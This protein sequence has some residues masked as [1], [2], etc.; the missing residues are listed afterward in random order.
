M[1]K[2][3]YNF[4][5]YILASRS[6]QLYVGMTNSLERR[7]QEHRA[8]Q[9]ESYTARYKI[10]RLVYFEHTQYVLNAIARETELKGWDRER[11]LA[12]VRSVNPTWIDLSEDW[13]ESVR[14]FWRRVEQDTQ[15]NADS[16]RE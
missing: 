5:V 2:R 8:A 4:Y 3:E 14:R 1:P 7:M 9:P 11:K 15:Q 16:L 13:G 10:G 6:L 12:L